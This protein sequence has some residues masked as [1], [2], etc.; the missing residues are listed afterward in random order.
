MFDDSVAQTDARIRSKL[1]Q[2]RYAA[3]AAMKESRKRGSRRRR[4]RLPVAGLAVTAAAV[5]AVL[6]WNGDSR[7]LMPGA[8]SV[9]DMELVAEVENLEMLQDVEFYAWLGRQP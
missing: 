4:L 8:L 3:M 1:T 7:E 6:L 9:E 5:V 2:A